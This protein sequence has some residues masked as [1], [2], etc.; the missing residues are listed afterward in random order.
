MLRV[1]LTRQRWDGDFQCR[2]CSLRAYEVWVQVQARSQAPGTLDVSWRSRTTLDP[3]LGFVSEKGIVRSSSLFRIVAAIF[4]IGNIDIASTRSDDA[5]M[6]DPS[7]AERVCHLL[8]IPLQ[9]FTR[10]LAHPCRPRMG[11]ARQQ[12]LEELAALCKTLY[13]KSFGLLVDR[14]NQALD[15]PSA[16]S[17]FI[18]VPMIPLHSV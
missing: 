18:G 14:V 16:K 4:H 12:A 8:G 9:E 10:A 7:Q 6:P 11:H 3:R 2:V 1:T 13:G 17:T 5:I 15:R